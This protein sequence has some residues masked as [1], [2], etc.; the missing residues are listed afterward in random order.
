MIGI[1][2][3]NN[4]FFPVLDEDKQGRAD[5]RTARKRLILTTVKNDQETVQIDLYRGESK[6]IDKDT[7][8]ASLTVE[9]IRISQSAETRTSSS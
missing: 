5:G 7:Y 6:E 9:N 8:L 3:A 2:L 4:T 1:R